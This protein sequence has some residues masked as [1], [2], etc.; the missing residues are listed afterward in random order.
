[1]TPTRR[2]R[3]GAAVDRVLDMVSPLSRDERHTL[4]RDE[5]RAL[6]ALRRQQRAGRRFIARCVRVNGSYF[7]GDV[8]GQFRPGEWLDG[9]SALNDGWGLYDAGKRSSGW[10]PGAAE[11]RANER[12]ER[13]R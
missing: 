8:P 12:D 5:R 6:A 1:M 4:D 7:P 2:E 13:N 11:L 9:Q 10:S 3:I